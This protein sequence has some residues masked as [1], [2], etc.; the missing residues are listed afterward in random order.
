M[1]RLEDGY[2]IVQNPYSDKMLW[3]IPISKDVVDCMVFW[4]KNPSS[5]LSKLEDIE[6][7][8]Y[9]F[10]FQF[11]ITPYGREIERN[12][13]SRDEMMAVFRRLSLITGLNRVIWRYDPVIL[14]EKFTV[15]WH[16]EQFDY[17]CS[18][19]KGYTRRCVFSFLDL[20]KHMLNDFEYVK[21][22]KDLIA[23][24]SGFAA[25]ASSYGISLSTCSEKMNLESLNIR[26]ASC[27]DREIIEDISGYT[28]D[29]GKDRNQRHECRCVESV[30]IGTYNTCHGGCRYCY[31][32]IRGERSGKDNFYDVNSPILGV[33][34][35]GDEYIKD[36]VVTSHRSSQQSLFK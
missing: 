30:D 4:T 5:M 21:N 12:V 15:S 23:V 32:T 28:I 27:I 17:M 20:Y 29:V 8:G 16:L 26:K 3:R 14:D 24:A 9:K 7:M 34:L 25:I 11:T 18:Y 6:N 19:L 31:A 2:V 1:K 22:K 35:R 10:Y 13:P 36:R 33:K